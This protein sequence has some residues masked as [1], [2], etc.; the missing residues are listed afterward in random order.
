MA[1]AMA[2]TYT[3]LLVHMVFATKDRR[4]LIVPGIRAELHAYMAGT[5]RRLGCHVHALNG[6][7]D[8]CHVVFDLAPMIS[9][10]DFA[11]KLK[12]GSTAW[13]RRER[14]LSDFGW[15][16]GY[17]AFS[18][19][20]QSLGRA[21]RYVDEQEAHHQKRSLQEELE[22]FMTL[23][24]MAVDPEFVRGTYQHPGDEG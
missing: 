14:G 22:A 10:A 19:S 1:T 13:L 2:S 15:Q 20:Q 16:R 17:G 21:I 7:A 9:V 4:P 24:G 12:A 3:R 18:L 11:N 8:H 23:H 5:A 6:V